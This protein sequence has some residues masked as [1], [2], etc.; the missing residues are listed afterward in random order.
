MPYNT[1]MKYR[2][3]ISMIEKNLMKI[4]YVEGTGSDYFMKYGKSHQKE[5]F[6]TQFL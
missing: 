2:K 1:L 4:C 5:D 3:K 6:I